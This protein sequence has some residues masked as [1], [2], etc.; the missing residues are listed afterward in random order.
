MDAGNIVKDVLKISL[1]LA[2]K[3]FLFLFWAVSRLSEIVLH[4]INKWLKDKL[5]EKITIK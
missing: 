3:T 2:W 4:H 1:N 5:N